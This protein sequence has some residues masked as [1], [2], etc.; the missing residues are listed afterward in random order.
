MF[1]TLV[2]ANLLNSI[3]PK[4]TYTHILLNIMICFFVPQGI[5]RMY[6]QNKMPVIVFFTFLIL[7]GTLITFFRKR[8][9]CKKLRLIYYMRHITAF[10][11]VT[12]ILPAQLFLSFSTGDEY[13]SYI[14]AE[15][16]VESGARDYNELKETLQNI[17]WSTLTLEEKSEIIGE[18]ILV[19]AENLGLK[20]LP[21]ITVEDFENTRTVAFYEN[22]M[23]HFNAYHL[24]TRSKAQCIATT[25]HELYHKYQIELID[26]TKTILSEE[27]LQ[28][29]YFDELSS[30][31]SADANYIKD[32]GHY[33]SYYKNDLEQSSREY[34]EKMLEKYGL[35]EKE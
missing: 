27:T 31:I 33:D 17:K 6:D 18:F 22:N 32:K 21:S 8:N 35:V 23:I 15:I 20:H 4:L 7:M 3:V 25:A 30:W 16:Q 29:Q 28:L 11:L 26:K 19:E 24:G 5:F 14:E 1:S 10:A 12:I 9:K 2:M 34:A 13:Y